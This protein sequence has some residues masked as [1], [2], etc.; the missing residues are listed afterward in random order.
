MGQIL[1][2]T[3]HTVKSA[4]KSTK[5]LVAEDD[6]I[7]LRLIR[8]LLGIVGF[9]D[10]TIVK[11]GKTAIK[12]ILAHNYDIVFCDWKMPE[13]D[14]IEFT[15]AVRRLPYYEKCG[16][17]IIMI[18][19]KTTMQDVALARDAGINEYLAKP[20]NLKVMSEKVKAVIENPRKYVMSDTYSGPDRRRHKDGRP[21][22]SERRTNTDIEEI[23]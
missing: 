5:V 21:P 7:M 13:L 15:R 12:E 8:D 11:D 3:E 17:P 19:G 20:F 14:G 23:K 9:D 18:T 10:I 2:S 16:I 6:P 1:M 22:A 4:L